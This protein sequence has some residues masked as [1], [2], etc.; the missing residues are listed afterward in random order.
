[1]NWHEFFFNELSEGIHFWLD[2]KISSLI[3][4][5]HLCLSLLK[6]LFY[7]RGEI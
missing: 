2:K 3:L 1:M 6:I 7:E 4:L 5:F